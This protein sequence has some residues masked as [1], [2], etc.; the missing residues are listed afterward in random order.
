MGINYDVEKLGLNTTLLFNQV[1]RRI[2]FVGS[3]DNSGG[4]PAIWEAP[5]P[6]LDLQIA[7]KV[8]KKKGEIKLNI[9][10]ILNYRANFY[11]DINGDG[12]YTKGSADVLA[13]TRNYGTTVSL[14][15]GYTIR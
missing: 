7:K 5:R 13:I 2:F 1:G 3:G 12:K 15:F 11:H 14:T 6:L 8:M 10:D 9:S 4:I